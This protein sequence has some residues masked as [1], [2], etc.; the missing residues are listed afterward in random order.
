MACNLA[1]SLQYNRIC[2]TIFKRLFSFFF[3]FFFFP[4]RAPIFESGVDFD[5]ASSQALMPTVIGGVKMPGMPE[6]GWR[7]SVVEH[8]NPTW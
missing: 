3:F 1:T 5:R 6:I 7:E 8:P 2:L 4:L